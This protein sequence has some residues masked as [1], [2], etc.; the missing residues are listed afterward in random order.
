[1]VLI[2]GSVNTVADALSRPPQATSMYLRRHQSESDYEELFDP[3]SEIEE[4]P[5]SQSADGHEEVI[6]AEKIKKESIATYQRNEPNLIEKA[7]ILKKKVEFHQPENLAVVVEEG[8]NRI[9]LPIELRLAA[10]NV[11]HQG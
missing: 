3:E 1:M 10:F 5:L 11:T 4:E 8:N 7:R 6:G 9:I 2:P